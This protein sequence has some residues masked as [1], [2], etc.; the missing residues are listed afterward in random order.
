MTTGSEMGFQLYYESTGG[1]GLT[2]GDFF[3]VV[4]YT[5]T[6]GS[7]IDGNKGYEMSDVDGIATLELDIVT[8]DSVSFDL[9]PTKTS[10]WSEFKLGDRR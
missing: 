2:D 10:E 3:G 1:V 5:G 8:A 4:D 7:F 9:C 6:V